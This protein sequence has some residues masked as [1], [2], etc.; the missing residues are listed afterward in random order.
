MHVE[1]ASIASWDFE[2]DLSNVTYLYLGDSNMY[3]PISFPQAINLNTLVVDWRHNGNLPYDGLITLP[4]L[5]SCKLANNGWLCYI[6]APALQNLC[7]YRIP[8]MKTK[9]NDTMLFLCESGCKL[10]CLALAY[11]DE[12]VGTASTREPYD[13]PLIPKMLTLPHSVSCSSSWA[14]YHWTDV[15]QYILLSI[16]SVFSPA[17]ALYDTRPMLP[18]IHIVLY[19]YI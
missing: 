11:I 8:A 16:L 14:L 3:P 13:V 5:E 1:V 12:P 15:Y 9:I 7:L 2:I 19:L 6:R 18:F 17:E 10:A 4:H